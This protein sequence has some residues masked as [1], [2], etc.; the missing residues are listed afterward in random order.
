M[1]AW[2][3]STTSKA[4][5][6]KAKI[7]NDSK[8]IQQG[9]YMF[10]MKICVSKFLEFQVVSGFL[11]AYLTTINNG[12]ELTGGTAVRAWQSTDSTNR[13]GYLESG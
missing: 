6:E 4:L 10:A 13:T 5:R 9:F 8:Q 7:P 12:G 3:N 1:F 11:G 2:W